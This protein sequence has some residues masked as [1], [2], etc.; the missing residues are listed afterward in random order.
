MT[1]VDQ[2]PYRFAKASYQLDM[3]TIYAPT[4]G[5][6]A[7]PVSGHVPDATGQRPMSYGSRSVYLER[8][9]YGR[10]A[11]AAE[12]GVMRCRGT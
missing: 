1:L 6:S 11:E 7:G 4:R 3:A 10:P 8:I 2:S 5:R 9:I 12:R